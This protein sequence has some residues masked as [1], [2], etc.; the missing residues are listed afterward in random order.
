MVKR[1]ISCLLLGALLAIMPA[2][3]ESWLTLEEYRR[4]E[5]EAPKQASNMLQAMRE[6]VFYAQSTGNGSVVCATPKPI[7]NTSLLAL[8]RQ[9]LSN[10]SN[11]LGRPYQSNDHVAFVFVHA[12]KQA[13]LCR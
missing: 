9:E 2:F 5:I 12:L 4:L 3:A 7:S 6:A 10:P 8:M 11:A 13:G 1:A